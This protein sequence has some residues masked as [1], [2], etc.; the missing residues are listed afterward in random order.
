MAL[1]ALPTHITAWLQHGALGS[2]I[3]LYILLTGVQSLLN[4]AFR[5]ATNGEWMIT[6][7]VPFKW[8]QRHGPSPMRTFL[9]RFPAMTVNQY[10]VL[11][12]DP[13]APFA[14]SQWLLMM[15]TSVLVEELLFRGIPLAVGHTTG[16]PTIWFLAV[17][18]VAWAFGHG[19][20]RGIVLTLT[21]GWFHV[22]LWAA[23]HAVLGITLH[24]AGNMSLAVLSA[25]EGRVQRALATAG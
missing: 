25:V 12:R 15:T 6:Q 11:K 2:L 10:G 21:F 13:T 9:E 1:T 5:T 20:G 16:G 22:G 7:P 17:G 8:W 23:G 19:I 18:T 4:M 14:R 24:L 3:G